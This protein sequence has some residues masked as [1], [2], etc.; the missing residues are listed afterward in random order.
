MFKVTQHGK[1]F[2]WDQSIKN[3]QN[4]CQGHIC[5]AHCGIRAIKICFPRPS[6]VWSSSY[7]ISKV[8]SEDSV[9]PSPFR[10]SGEA[11]EAGFSRKVLS[12]YKEPSKQPQE[13]IKASAGCVQPSL[14]RRPGPQCLLLLTAQGQV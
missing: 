6:R 9:W 5:V 3:S 12:L 8:A 7:L 11:G 14:A 2:S 1:H 4:G 10:H 13:S